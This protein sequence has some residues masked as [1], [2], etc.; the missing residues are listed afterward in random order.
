MPERLAETDAD[1]VPSPP[2]ALPKGERRWGGVAARWAF[3]RV[4][5]RFRPQGV[6]LGYRVR[7]LRGR[8]FWADLVPRAMPW[9]VGL[10]PFG[11]AMV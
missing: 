8:G 3:L 2:A 7:P 11:A 4:W 5:C 9:A 10:G 6:A 1:G